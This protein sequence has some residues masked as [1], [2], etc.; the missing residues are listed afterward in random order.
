VNIP[1]KTGWII[2]CN[3]GRE[4]GGEISDLSKISDCDSL[5]SRERSLAVN[6]SVATSNYWRSWRTAGILCFNKSFRRI[7]PF[8]QAR[9]RIPSLGVRCKNRFKMNFRSKNRIKNPTPS[10]LRDLTP[11]KN[12]RLLATPTPWLQDFEISK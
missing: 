6:N 11:P 3:Q 8:Q 2:C 9:A 12:L 1:R 7:V 4:V 5:A 10:F